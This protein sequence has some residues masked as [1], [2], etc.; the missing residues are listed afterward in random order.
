MELNVTHMIEAINDSP[1]LVGSIAQYGPNAAAMTWGNSKAFGAEHPL[2]KTDEERAAARDHFRS[3]GAWDDAEID[4]WSEEELQGIT[5]QE[6][7]HQI[8]ELEMFETEEEYSAAAE[9]GTVSGRLGK[10]DDGQWYCYF[11]D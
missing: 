1:P 5:C 8:S 7:A 9:R 11:G 4:G 2:L 6:V 3:Y 10:G